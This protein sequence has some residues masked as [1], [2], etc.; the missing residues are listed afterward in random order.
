M[1]SISD[2]NKLR[3]KGGCFFDS[4]DLEIFEKKIN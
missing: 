2:I 1:E 4:T 3:L